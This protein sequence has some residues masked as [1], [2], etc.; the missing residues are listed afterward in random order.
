MSNGPSWL[1]QETARQMQDQQNKLDTQQKQ[2]ESQKKAEEEQLNQ[3]KLK[4]LSL[5]SGQS[6]LLNPTNQQ[7]LLG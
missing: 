2:L 1:E 4:S 6:G 7:S 5:F 3:K